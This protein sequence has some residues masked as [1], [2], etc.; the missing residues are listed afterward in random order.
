M[1]S[2][3]KITSWC[4]VLSNLQ[5]FIYIIIYKRKYTTSTENFWVICIQLFDFL[6]GI[7]LIS[8]NVLISHI[9]IDFKYLLETNNYSILGLFQEEVSNSFKFGI[10]QSIVVNRYGNWKIKDDENIIE[11]S[12]EIIYTLCILLGPG[13]QFLYLTNLF[14][15]LFQKINDYE[16]EPFT[17]QDLTVYIIT[18]KIRFGSITISSAMLIILCIIFNYIGNDIKNDRNICKNN[19]KKDKSIKIIK[20]SYYEEKNDEYCKAN[21]TSKMTKRGFKSYFF[22]F[23]SLTFLFEILVPLYFYYLPSTDNIIY[24]P[25]ILRNLDNIRSIITSIVFRHSTKVCKIKSDKD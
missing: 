22:T 5:F 3:L 12:N 6:K 18:S 16:V 11:A 4:C 9:S 2:I 24:I 8:F 15:L 23:F 17:I 25:W 19:K 10:W 21:Y 7:A 20:Y 1:D 14:P 13:A